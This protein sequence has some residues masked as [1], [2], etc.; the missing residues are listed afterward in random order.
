MDR[1]P[2]TPYQRKLQEFTLTR[3]A[4]VVAMAKMA[5]MGLVQ[6]EW[7]RNLIGK[8]A[9]S[10]YRDAFAVGVELEASQLLGLDK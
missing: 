3:I 1:T 10:L 7:Q 5:Q 2:V 6:D 8:A 9:T 4:Y